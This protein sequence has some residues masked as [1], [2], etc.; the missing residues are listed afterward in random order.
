MI[1]KIKQML[2]YIKLAN[3]DMQLISLFDVADDKESFIKEYFEAT[4]GK[5]S[6]KQEEDYSNLTFLTKLLISNSA[7]KNEEVR[8]LIRK[9][10]MKYAKRMD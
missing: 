2:F 6:G 10:L 4:Q 1:K 8:M 9:Y 5:S 7:K 3:A